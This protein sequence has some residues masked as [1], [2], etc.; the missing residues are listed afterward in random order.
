MFLFQKSFMLNTA[1]DITEYPE[2]EEEEQVCWLF[3]SR[4]GHTLAS[5][6]PQD[7]HFIAIVISLSGSKQFLP[8][9]VSFYTKARH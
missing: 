2:E 4:D 9:D 8:K 5:S 1:A 7:H 3:T 6:G